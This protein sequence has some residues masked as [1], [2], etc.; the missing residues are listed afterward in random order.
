MEQT[1]TVSAR[2]RRIGAVSFSQESSLIGIELLLGLLVLYATAADF[3][4]RRD[5]VNAYT[6]PNLPRHANV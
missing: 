5:G 3:L 4:P 2:R 1:V 6:L